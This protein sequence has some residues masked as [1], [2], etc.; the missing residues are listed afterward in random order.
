MYRPS[1]ALLCC[2]VLPAA[3]LLS[4]LRCGAQTAVAHHPAVKL[5][6]PRKSP[7]LLSNDLAAFAWEMF[8]YVN[9]PELKGRRGEPDSRSFI[10]KPGA[11]VWE[12]YKNEDEIYQANGERPV[13]WEVHDELPVLSKAEAQ[14]LHEKIEALEPVDSQ[15][16]HFLAEPR[17]I[18]GQ[19]ICDSQKNPIQYD[20]RENIS[21]YNYVVNN[22][23]GHQ[24]YNIQGQQAALRDANFAFSFPTDTLEVKASWRILEPGVSGNKFWTAVGVYWDNN[25]ELQVARIGLT[26]LHIISRILPDW[27]WITFEQVDNADTTFECA[28]GGE[29]KPVGPNPNYDKGLSTINHDFQQALENTKWQYYRLMKVQAKFLNETQKPILMSNTQMETYFQPTSSCITCHKLASVGLPKNPSQ[30]LRLNF[31]ANQLGYTGAIDFRKIA[32]QQF[33]GE[34]F[35]EMD[36]V[37]SLRNAHFLKSPAKPAR[38]AAGK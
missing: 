14:L 36:F 19:Q 1:H 16:V 37:W 25:H 9:W 12:S 3:L 26:G 33:P 2:T 4:T 18:D 29:N 34:P 38:Q 8:I 10:G 28:V 20:V 35:K 6:D 5:A 15:W 30:N 7:A 31:F 24:L 22:L 21:Y 23:S 13:A 11:T 17:M 32:Q 27:V